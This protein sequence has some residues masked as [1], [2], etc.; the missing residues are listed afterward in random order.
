M[1][2]QKDSSPIYISSNSETSSDNENDISFVGVGKSVVAKPGYCK[3]CKVN[4]MDVMFFPCTHASICRECYK[5][6]ETPK[7]CPCCGV[8]ITKDVDFYL[9]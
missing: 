5:K 4:I 7:K 9:T 2:Q 1:S 8:K 3:I 6:L